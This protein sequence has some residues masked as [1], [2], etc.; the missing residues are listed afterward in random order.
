VSD[1][2]A[3]KFLRGSQA[4]YAYAYKPH[5]QVNNVSAAIQQS[6]PHCTVTHY[7]L[8]MLQSVT[9][10]TY[11]VTI[12]ICVALGM[13]TRYPVTWLY[14]RVHCVNCWLETSG[15]LLAERHGERRYGWPAWLAFPS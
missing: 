14:R 2:L 8:Q 11:F 4:D 6:L 10:E 13:Q 3:S 15:K 12:L 9:Q 7:I 5:K 1:N